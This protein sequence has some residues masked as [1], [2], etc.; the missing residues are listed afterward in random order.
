MARIAT[1]DVSPICLG[2]NVFGWTIDEAAS[3]EVLD[4]F[5]EA[6]G[7]FIDTAD[8]YSSWVKGNTGGDSEKIIGAWMA[9]RGNRDSIV[10]ATKVGMLEGVEGLSRDSIRRGVEASLE[11]LQTDVIDLFYA[12]KDDRDTPLEDTMAALDELVVEGKVRHLGAS[13]Y[14]ADRLRSAMEVAVP[15]S[16]VVLQPL[17]NLADR[18]IFEDGLASAVTDTGLAVVPY[19]ALASGFLTGK[20]RGTDSDPATGRS[21]KALTYL[22]DR[23]LRILG[24]MD[25]VAANHGVQLASI[26][27]AWLASRPSVVAPL[28]SARTTEQLSA[29]MASLDVELQPDELALLDDASAA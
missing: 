18:A 24:A 25:Q 27:L 20:Y 21:P 13:N 17:Y 10:I 28:A 2:G 12:H 7:N 23:G 5:A 14:S 15:N 26:A 6:G 22:D 16:Y 19:Y 1:L 4:A 8:V 9:S 3:F 29:L 11:R